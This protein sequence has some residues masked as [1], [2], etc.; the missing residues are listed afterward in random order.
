MVRRILCVC[1]A[2]RGR[3][4]VLAAL[5]RHLLNIAGREDVEIESAGILQKEAGQPVGEYA[6]AAM[7]ERGIDL[8]SHQSRWIGEVD[9]DKFD[10]VICMTPGISEIVKTRVSA[11]M[12]VIV[13][14]EENDG[15]PD[16]YPNGQLRE[17]Q[18]CLETLERVAERIVNRYFPSPLRTN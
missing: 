12:E 10:L 2:N 13:A 5:L 7:A 17:Y 6:I 8:T 4:P 11:D 1:N 16:P 3:S 9:L 18:Q 15:V 14:N